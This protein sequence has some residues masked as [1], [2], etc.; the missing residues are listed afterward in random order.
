MHIDE[1]RAPVPT[2]LIGVAGHEYGRILRAN[3]AFAELV[4]ATTETVRGWRISD[5]FH[6]RDRA[7]IEQAFSGLISATVTEYEGD[8]SLVAHNGRLRFVTVTATLLSAQTRRLLLLRIV[9]RSA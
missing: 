8:A 9:E 3:H 2:A 5:V 6:E 7:R 1:R 4:A